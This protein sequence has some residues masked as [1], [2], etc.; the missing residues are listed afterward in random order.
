MKNLFD[1]KAKIGLSV[2]CATVLL[3][4]VLILANHLTGLL[5]KSATLL[6]TSEN[7]MYS[8]SA[9]AKK[10]IAS[11]SDDIKI[12]L[13]SAGGKASLDDTGIHL[14]TFLNRLAS[15]NAKIKYT[16]VDLYSSDNFLENRGI[17]SS[18]V[19]L[20]SVI[21]ESKL[22]NRYI[23]SS[24]LFY[25]YIEGVGKVSKNEMFSL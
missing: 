22:R 1:N 20:N 8:I 4:A 12:Y 16:L 13:L 24:E 11:Y 23:D 2:I 21:V 17:D 18:K 9:S 10:S 5:P 6:D 15:H 14:D 7:D 19:T 3:L 25:Y